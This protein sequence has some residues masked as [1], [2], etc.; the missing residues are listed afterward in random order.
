MSL[1]ALRSECSR[2]SARAGNRPEPFIV[3]AAA[4]VE[5]PA[6][7][8]PRRASRPAACRDVVAMPSRFARHKI[9]ECLLLD[10]ARDAPSID[11]RC[12]FGIGSRSALGF[13]YAAGLC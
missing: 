1:L 13:C 3:A 8:M 12:N 7:R 5:P 9:A 11:P 10:R 2:D 6:K 4:A